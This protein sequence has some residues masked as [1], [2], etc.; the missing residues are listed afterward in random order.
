MWKKRKSIKRKE[1]KNRYLCLEKME[2][3][4][5]IRWIPLKIGH[6]RWNSKKYAPK[7]GEKEDEPH[8]Y[9]WFLQKLVVKDENNKLC[10]KITS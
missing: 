4:L 7:A 3:T 8:I 6:Q 10:W 2:N 1:I 9:A 5:K